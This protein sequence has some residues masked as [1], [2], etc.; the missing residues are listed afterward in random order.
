[1]CRLF[2]NYN[3]FLYIVSN[4]L[5]NSNLSAGSA[6]HDLPGMIYV[7]ESKEGGL[8]MLYS[9]KTTKSRTVKSKNTTTTMSGRKYYGVISG[10]IVFGI[11]TS[12]QSAVNDAHKRWGDYFLGS[13]DAN[14]YPRGF[15]RNSLY[16]SVIPADMY[17]DVKN[18]NGADISNFWKLTNGNFTKKP[19]RNTTV[20]ELRRMGYYKR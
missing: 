1:M 20:N 17:Y 11:G 2:P 13:Y 18:T 15:V 7:F 3:V 14:D 12:P 6:T 19:G 9:K 8:K 4:K 16:I 5:Q 10:E